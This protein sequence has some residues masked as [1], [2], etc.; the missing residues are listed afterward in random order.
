MVRD[1]EAEMPLLKRAKDEMPKPF[2]RTYPLAPAIDEVAAAIV[3]RRRRVTYPKWFMKLLPL[4]QLFA[5]P[6]A[7][8][9]AGNGVAESLREYDRLVAERGATAV[10]ASERTRE[11][12]RLD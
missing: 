7:E 3:Q 12:A 1:G 9:Q 5:S 10:S 6:F 4:R 11:L 2:S 8:R